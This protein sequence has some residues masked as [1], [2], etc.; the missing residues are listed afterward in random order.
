MPAASTIS[1]R[2]SLRGRSGPSDLKALGCPKVGAL[3]ALLAIYKSRH[4]PE[5]VKDFQAFSRYYT[6]M[7]ERLSTFKIVGP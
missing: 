7:D 1:R 2:K 6:H 4:R 3:M 5:C